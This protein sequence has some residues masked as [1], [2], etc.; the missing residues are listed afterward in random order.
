MDWAKLMEDMEYRR[1]GKTTCCRGLVEIS[2]VWLGLDHAFGGPRPLIFETMAFSR[3]PWVSEDMDR[4]STEAEAIA[5]HE[6]MVKKWSSISGHLL[7]IWDW[8]KWEFDLKVYKWR[9]LLFGK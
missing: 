4:Y 8:I 1:I 7:G 2:T 6:A 3:L 9:R 5:G